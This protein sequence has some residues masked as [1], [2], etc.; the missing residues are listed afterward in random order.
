MEYIAFP[1]LGF[2]F[3]VGPVLAEFEL[4]G[5]PF[6][7]RWYGVM[8]ALGFLLAVLYGVRCAHRFDIKLDPMLDVALVATVVAVLCARIYYILFHDGIATFWEDPLRVFRIW[9]GGL[10]IYGGVIG[11]FV[12]GIWMCKLRKV[13][14]L[15]MFDLASLGFLI[16]QGIGRW[17][18]FFNQEAFGGNTD[19]PWGMTGSIIM[20]GNNGAD[21]NTALP[22]HPTFLYESIWDLVGFLFLFLYYKKRKFRG[23]ISLMYLGW[24][25]MIRFLTEFLRTD[26]LYI[27]NTGIRSSQLVGGLCVVISVS[28]LTYFSTTKKY[29]KSFVKPG[30]EIIKLENT[31]LNSEE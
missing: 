2:L 20:T 26:S 9:D 5:I 28:L 31:E 19:L 25:G 10:A 1:K 13:P 22:V 12:T 29:P 18:N 11:A 3:E 24:Y 30:D 23:E 17:G 4:F 21:Y 14:T 6:S 27:G 16:G 15:K 8:I 7:I